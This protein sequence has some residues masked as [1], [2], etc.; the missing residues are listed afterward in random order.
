MFMLISLI[1]SASPATPEIFKEELEA[2]LEQVRDEVRKYYQ[3]RLYDVLEAMEE[4]YDPEND[5]DLIKER[6]ARK[7][8]K[9]KEPGADEPTR[10]EK[11]TPVKQAADENQNDQGRVSSVPEYTKA[12]T[13]EL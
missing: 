3:S 4:E 2:H 12:S 8:R 6:K 10:P 11:V 13:D 5:E 1:F 9:S 7:P